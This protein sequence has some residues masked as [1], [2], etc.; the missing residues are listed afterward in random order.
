[1]RIIKWCEGGA[2][3]KLYKVSEDGTDD[4]K[5]TDEWVG[6]YFIEGEYIYYNVSQ[7]GIDE[8]WGNLYKKHEGKATKEDLKFIEEYFTQ[9]DDL[10]G[11]IFRIKLDGTEK[12]RLF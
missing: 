11:A 2:P 6:S 3:N 1:M 8:I 7:S 5:I 12:I 10:E 4:K 9:R